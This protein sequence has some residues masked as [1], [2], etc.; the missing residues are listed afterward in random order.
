MEGAINAKGVQE[1]WWKTRNVTYAFRSVGTQQG[2]NGRR[3]S[4]A[5]GTADTKR[6]GGT[7]DSKEANE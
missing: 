5:K 7:I 2:G 4:Q 6:H 1:G 3:V